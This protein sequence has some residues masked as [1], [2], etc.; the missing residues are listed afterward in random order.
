MGYKKGLS[1]P[2]SFYHKDWDIRTVVHGDEF[3]SEGPAESLKMMKDALEKEFRG[4]TELIGP[5]PEQQLEARVLNWVI[6]WE[7]TGITFEL[8]PRHAEIMIE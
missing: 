8:D 1:S 2:C 7:E 6:R 3:L 4:K 5:D